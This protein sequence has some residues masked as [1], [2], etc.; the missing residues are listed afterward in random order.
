MHAGTDQE[1]LRDFARS[2]SDQAFEAV[3]R[4]HLGLVYATARRQLGDASLAEEVTQ[5]V[6]LSLARKADALQHHGTIAGWLHQSTLL[7]CRHHLRTE[8]R[9]QRRERAAVEAETLQAASN[10]SWRT[11]APMLDE[12]L[13]Q[14]GD[15][16]R[17]LLLLRFLEEKSFRAV[18]QELGITEEAA[19]KRVNKALA[20][21]TKFF[22]KEGFSIPGFSAATVASDLFPAALHPPS[23]ELLQTVL[24]LKAAVVA[25]AT[26]GS[27]IGAGAATTGSLNTALKT[28][29]L[30]TAGK[31]KTIVWG[32]V[33]LL[34]ALLLPTAL[35]WTMRQVHQG[36]RAGTGRPQEMSEGL[37]RIAAVRDGVTRMILYADSHLG[38]LPT[39]VEQL[40]E[41]PSHRD[42]TPQDWSVLEI[43]GPTELEKIQDPRTTVILQEKTADK[44]GKRVRGYA[45]GHSMLTP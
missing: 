1:R 10:T 2:G 29:L 36:M 20:A 9:R 22:Q 23:P 24:E 25:A 40:G 30:M 15:R 34:L 21:L 43:V 3:V 28:G 44:N 27:A 17:S 11:L 45:D 14:L 32:L 4:E 5:N 7:E 38:M 6:F 12:A 42:G 8:L 41:P 39:R 31:S 33:F 13:L 37:R 35:H 19:R 18:G 26:S 16:D